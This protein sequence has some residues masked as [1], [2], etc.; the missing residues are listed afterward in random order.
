MTVDDGQPVL[1]D[2]TDPR[3]VLVDWPWPPLPARARVDWQ[4]RVVSDA[5]R[6][7]WSDLAHVEIGL[8]R[9]DWVAAWVAPVEDDRPAPG[10]RPGYLLRRAFDIAGGGADE[11]GD[12]IGRARVYATAHGLYELFVN[13]SRVG[14]AE[15]TP[16]Y[17]SYRANLAYQ[18]Y[19]VTSLLH[20]GRN[21]VGVLLS[22][23]WYR[24]RVGYY[25]QPDAFGDSVAAL[26]Q[27]EIVGPGGHQTVTTDDA[28]EF[29]TGS[30]VAADLMD[31]ESIDLDRSRPTWSEPG[32]SSV[33]WRAVGLVDGPAYDLDRLTTSPAPPVRT[34][35][36]LPAVSLTHL[37]PGRSAV[38]FGQNVNGWVRLH[39][40]GGRSLSLTHGEAAT[41]TG[42]VTNDHLAS[43]AHEGG[44]L[45]PV[46]MIDHV[47]GVG[48]G[49]LGLPDGDVEFRHT[50]HGF[51]YVRLEGDTDDLSPDQVSAAVVHT[52]LVRTGWFGCSDARLNRL[53][54][55]AVW[56]FRGNACDI[57]TDCPHRERAGWTGDWQLY[58]PTAAFLYDVAG[59]SVKWLRDLVADQRA[60]GVILNFAPE[61]NA[62]PGGVELLPPPWDHMQG[63][64]GW[65]EAIVIVPWE[66]Y[67]AYGDV[68]V[69][70]ETYPA[71]LKWLEYATTQAATRRHEDA[72]RRR[73]AAADHEQFLWDTGYHWGEW[74]EPVES[75]HDPFGDE[76]IVATAYF[77]RA[78]D[79]M[80]RIADVIG[81]TEDA[82]AFGTLA[83]HIRDAWRTEYVG[84]DGTLARDTQA[85]Y[86]RALTFGL[87][88]DGGREAAADRLAEL[89]RAHGDHL[90][91]GFLSTPMLL[92]RLADAGHWDVAF[93]L[94]RQDTIPSWLVMIDRGATTI[95]EDWEGIDE[96]GAPKASLNHYSKG[97]VISFLHTHVVGLTMA[98][99]SVAYEHFVV[100]PHADGSGLTWA[101]ATLDCPYGRIEAGWEIAGDRLTVT[102]A[103][104]PGTSGLLRIGG[105][106]T[107]VGPGRHSF[108]APAPAG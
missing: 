75:G 29:A 72:V 70:T 83:G 98:E 65:A 103:A 79:L 53:H 2:R 108:V 6:S 11:I 107:E 91:T 16:G 73:P 54:D 101:A 22:D 27:L 38:D 40:V 8:D 1:V 106:E 99:G 74:L 46:G 45:L 4:V 47:R 55:L 25:R 10:E 62:A 58:V 51:Q 80:A 44:G 39:D 78:A 36:Y 96:D 90:S 76:G 19:D 21:V 92:P 56:S 85:T 50:T 26:L 82:A 52:D 33:G 13:G 63:S 69:L 31:G 84:A 30:V 57:P 17:T 93:D 41:A 87:I 9:D 59:F 64:S 15:L 28:W 3:S 71:M 94:L 23:G 43:H 67:R 66:L 105:I 32:D 68:S 102:V 49:D 81:R 100:E 88:P 42:D 95:W 12:R 14:D 18:T 60:N 7:E 35:E 48:A 86:A 97:A 89:V 104:P 24:G 37:E 61:P 77:Y 34:V 5:G 20:T